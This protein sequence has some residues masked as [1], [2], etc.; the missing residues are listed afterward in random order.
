MALPLSEGQPVAQA[1]GSRQP[2]RPEVHPAYSGLAGLPS[3]EGLPRE[4]SPG[5]RRRTR[6]PTPP[7]VPD[8]PAP[9]L[10]LLAEPS[11]PDSA[12]RD[13]HSLVA[14]SL[15][16]TAPASVTARVRA[17]LRASPCSHAGRGRGAR[18][19]LLLPSCPTLHPSRGGLPAPQLSD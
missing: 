13:L 18:V 5:A 1:T 2:P 4:V 19:P 15:A 8:G 14:V 16:A 10:L 11:F 3:P 17:G 7:S 9:L 6:S 12:P